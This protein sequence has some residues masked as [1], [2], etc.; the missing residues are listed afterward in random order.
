MCDEVVAVNTAVDDEAKGD[1][2]VVVAAGREALREER[3][4]EGAG[5]VD[6]AQLGA[7]GG[8]FTGECA[9][10]LVDEV[11][12]PGGGED[13][14]ARGSG[15]GVLIHGSLVGVPGTRACRHAPT[16]VPGAC[17]SLSSGL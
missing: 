12:V 9:D 8:E 16:G 10:G 1:D 6:A 7:V 14:D 5:H 2:R 3:D 4:L 11:A 17:R 15:G 13:R